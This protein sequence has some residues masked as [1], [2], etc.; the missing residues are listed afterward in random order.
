M[1]VVVIALMAFFSCYLGYKTSK[2]AHEFASKWTITILASWVGVALVLIIFKIC[3]IK[4]GILNL[5]GAAT[6]CI[7]GAIFGKKVNR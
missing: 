6:G 3:G 5:A 4:N 2:F 1:H 7:G